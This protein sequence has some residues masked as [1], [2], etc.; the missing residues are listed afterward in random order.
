MRFRRYLRVMAAC[1]GGNLEMDMQPLRELVCFLLCLP[2]GEPHLAG[3][4]PQLF[5][6]RFEVWHLS[7]VCANSFHGGRR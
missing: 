7:Y 6:E 1:T 4:D 5:G 3:L 2:G